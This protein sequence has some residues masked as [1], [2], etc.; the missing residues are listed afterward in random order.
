MKNT[1]DSTANL[2]LLLI[3]LVAAFIRIW[4]T[5]Q[6]SIFGDYDE[7]YTAMTASGIYESKVLPGPYFNLNTLTSDSFGER[8]QDANR[9]NGNS[10]LYNL[11][12]SY[13]SNAFGHSE[14]SMRLF[15]TGFDLLSIL[16]VWLIGKKLGIDKTRRLLSCLLYA[17]YPVMVNYAGIIRT[18]S[19]TTCCALLLIL[20][21]LQVNNEKWSLKNTLAIGLIATG[22]FLGHFL[23][24][25]ILVVLFIY[26]LF[27]YKKEK[28]SSLNILSG[29]SAAAIMCGGFLLF[30]MSQLTNFSNSSKRYENLAGKS[31]QEGNMRKLEPVSAGTLAPKTILYFDQ[32][33]TGN[34]YAM[35]WVQALTSDKMMYISGLF[36][37]AI[38]LILLFFLEKNDDNRKWIN[39]WLSIIVAG[40]LGALVLVFLS[41]HMISLAIKYTMFSIPLYLM[42]VAFYSKRNLATRGALAALFAGSLFT[43]IGS[44]SSKG[45]KQVKIV[46]NGE[47]KDY[48]SKDKSQVLAEMAS[49]IK[50][51][52]DTIFVK[53]PEELVFIEMTGLRTTQK[54]G[55]VG[56]LDPDA[57]Y[58]D[59]CLPFSFQIPD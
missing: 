24:Y 19:F 7:Y 45:N 57:T 52:P 35:K 46:F 8:L 59:R 56:N 22:L 30:N 27:R 18:Y 33:Y 53:S 23:T 40:H 41:G 47:E 54:T 9:D 16:L 49:I 3:I 36:L 55:Y 17:V 39:L 21:I 29:L 20:L 13:T 5:D 28:Y 38:P 10:F 25:Y 14:M 11:I 4:Q 34:T 42:L 50:E 58:L 1:I 15:S 32:F 48:K 26:Y 37:L 2:L 51:N 6:Y 31:V 44:F 12:L 43:C